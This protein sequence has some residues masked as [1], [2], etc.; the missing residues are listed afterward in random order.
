MRK[1]YNPPMPELEGDSTNKR[2]LDILQEA[3]RGRAFL[4]MRGSNNYE[5]G[6]YTIHSLSRTAVRTITAQ[7]MFFDGTTDEINFG[8]I[9]SDIVI[10]L[11]KLQDYV[12]RY[13]TSHK[14]H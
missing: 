7:R 13:K 11:D 14:I 10:P 6:P 8:L 12:D 9:T 4:P 3:V 1:D 5:R 2:T